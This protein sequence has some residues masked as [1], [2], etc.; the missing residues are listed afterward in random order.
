MDK[1]VERIIKLY[2]SFLEGK[3]VNKKEEAERFEVNQRTV[4][5]DID[6]IRMC[7]ANDLKMNWQIV[8][9]RHK[10]GYVLLRDG[11]ERLNSQEILML[12]EVFLQ[13]KLLVKEEM[14][15]IVDKLVQACVSREEKK[16][17]VSL[18]A[19]EKMQYEEPEHGKRLQQMMKDISDA[20]YTQRVVQIHYLINVETEPVW[21]VVQPVGIVFSEKHL[22]LTAYVHIKD[23]ETR[24]VKEKRHKQSVVY[25]LDKIIDYSILQEHF[26]VP[27]KN[28]YVETDFHNLIQR[29]IATTEEEL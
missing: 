18:L 24:Y 10:N 7:F 21:Q 13:S 3:V 29:E 5:R 4:Q 27:Y 8:Y 25:R 19:K 23:E 14:F 9:D 2:S 20:I 11:E 28:Q 15:S 1:K 22:Y 26:H 12:C 6:D 17:I 16:K